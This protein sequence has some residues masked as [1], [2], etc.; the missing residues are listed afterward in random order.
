MEGKITIKYLQ[1][2][3]KS[4]DYDPDAKKEYFLKLSEEIGELARVIRRGAPPAT[5]ASLKGTVEEELWDIIYYT[6]AIANTYD[7]D[8]EKWIPIKEAINNKKY[9][10]NTV[11]FKPKKAMKIN[12]IALYT[13]DLERMKQFY[14]TYFGAKSN[15]GYHN[16]NTGLRTYFLSF[17]DDTGLE[18]MTRPNLEQQGDSQVHLGYIH[19]AFS[20][21]SKENVD[22]LTT[23][24]EKDGFTVLSKPRTTGDGYY[25]S[26]VLDPDG[27]QIEIVE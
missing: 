27:N 6:L 11:E 20:V 24:L 18:L 19:L 22:S 15:Q 4:K 17:D 26:C 7:I 2:Y 3:I 25:E 23:S 1:E 9:N 14:I 16:K 5:E 8:V 21:G 13:D 12:H 10:N